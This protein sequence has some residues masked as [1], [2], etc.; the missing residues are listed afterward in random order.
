[1]LNYINIICYC[2][3]VLLFFIFVIIYILCI[4]EWS[5]G[6]HD[7]KFEEMTEEIIRHNTGIS[8]DLSPGSEE[9][10]YLP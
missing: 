10:G 9:T 5:N 2:W 7:G 8:L 3:T 1:M 6:I 4:N